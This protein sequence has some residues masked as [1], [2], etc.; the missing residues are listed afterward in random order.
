MK[1]EIKN[2]YLVGEDKIFKNLDELLFGPLLDIKDIINNITLND[3]IIQIDYDD[4][5]TTSEKIY[6]KIMSN[7]EKSVENPIIH[8][9]IDKNLKTQDNQKLKI[10]YRVE[11]PTI[12]SNIDTDILWVNKV[13]GEIFTC[14]DNTINQ[15]IWQGQLGTLIQPNTVPNIYS[16]CILHLPMDDIVGD[17]LE[18]KSNNYNVR[19]RNCNIGVGQV[20]SSVKFKWNSNVKVLNSWNL[21][22]NE[23]FELNFW[24]KVDSLS[25]RSNII[26]KAYGGEFSV[27]LETSGAISLY[28]G[29]CGCN[30]WPYSHIVS[31]PDTVKVGNWYHITIIRN[32]INSVSFMI[33]NIPK[34]P[35]Q[36]TYRVSS[37]ESSYN[38]I[39]IGSGYQHSLNGSLDDLWFHNRILTQQERDYIF[40]RR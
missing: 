3:N 25:R 23:T 1:L 28:Y 26:H 2:K 32:N 21:T 24:I 27:V 17:R 4:T 6:D 9:I 33:N 39:L 18:E 38:P 35:Y 11:D 29:S 8:E 19:A 12:D 10:I 7:I 37:I 22:I 31:N 40:S 30:C 15:N 14:V 34:S 16:D 13:T 20:N 36:S 5:F